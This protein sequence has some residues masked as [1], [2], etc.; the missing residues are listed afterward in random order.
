VI[1]ALEAH[2][3]KLGCI[4]RLVAGH[5]AFY[6]ARNATTAHDRGVKRVCIP[7][8]STQSAERKREQKKRWFKPG[9]NWRTGGEA[10]S[11]CGRGDT[12]FD[13][14]STGA[15]PVGSGGSDFGVVADH[16]HHLGKVLA[17]R[18]Y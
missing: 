4:P 1:P 2:E 11:A 15:M 9:Q 8:R 18:Q 3:N 10:A 6:S 14:V 7:H 13:D 5:A 17:E 16:L 12:A